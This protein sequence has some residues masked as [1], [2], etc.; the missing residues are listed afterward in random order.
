M[1]VLVSVFVLLSTGIV[2][3]PLVVADLKSD[4]EA[5]ARAKSHAEEYQKMADSERKQAEEASRKV[6]KEFWEETARKAKELAEIHQ[7]EADKFKKE[8]EELTRKEAG[9]PRDKTTLPESPQEKPGTESKGEEPP[10]EE[11]SKK[12]PSQNPAEKGPE[13]TPK[14]RNTPDPWNG[15]EDP[16]PANGIP[17]GE[18]LGK[19]KDEKTEKDIN[20][21]PMYH[22]ENPEFVLLRGKHLWSGVYENGKFTFKYTPKYDEMNSEA[23]EWARRKVAQEGKLIWIME[24]EPPKKCSEETML[25]GFW[26]PGEI[27]WKSTGADETDTSSENEARATGEKGKP[28]PVKLYKVELSKYEEL[29]FQGTPQIHLR[30]EGQPPPS[31][32][33]EEHIAFLTKT[34]PFYIEVVVNEADTGGKD[35]IEIKLK[36]VKAGLTASLKLK[37]QYTVHGLVHYSHDDPI[38]LSDPHVLS[39]KKIQ[40]IWSDFFRLWTRTVNGDDL[41]ISY[42]DNVHSLKMF[43]SYERQRIGQL[44]DAF[45]VA[46]K[47]FETL[48][49]SKSSREQQ[50]YAHLKL[51]YIQN[52]RKLLE[53]KSTSAPE[54]LPDEVLAEILGYYASKLEADVGGNAEGT[55]PVNWVWEPYGIRVS[56]EEEKQEIDRILRVSHEK[57]ADLALSA[58]AQMSVALYQATVANAPGARFIVVV[59]GIDAAGNPV[60][61]TE[62]FL[63]G[64]QMGTQALGFVASSAKTLK[65]L[66]TQGTLNRSG[67]VF[68]KTKD[69]KTVAVPKPQGAISMRPGALGPGG[70]HLGPGVIG[71]SSIHRWPGEDVRLDAPVRVPSFNSLGTPLQRYAD[72]CGPSVLAG[73]Y[74]DAG[75]RVVGV[76][77]K[78][79]LGVVKD[80]FPRLAEEKDV[81]RLSMQQGSYD[82]TKKVNGVTDHGGMYVHQMA[83]MT[84]IAGTHPPQIMLGVPPLQKLEAALHHDYKMAVVI[85]SGPVKNRDVTHWVRL[86]GVRCGRDGRKWVIFGDPHNGASWAAPWSV[87]QRRMV[88]DSTVAVKFKD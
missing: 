12:D 68:A 64:L 3:S 40:V 18:L 71:S 23:P 84:S 44:E 41:E 1:A 10:Q 59:W 15:T 65:S 52:A 86:E 87:F 33:L 7:K 22:G 43:E 48:I 6:P 21:E 19:W 38:L 57:M 83:H 66:H 30:L 35:T 32:D 20:L 58:L 8:A 49:S 88:P 29:A 39:D 62:R 4:Q 61:K 54:Q 9:A 45:N 79:R 75:R 24:L 34:Q 85:Y 36:A 28:I 63:A 16:I 2:A 60:D 13:E 82:I 76:R 50:A 46:D 81:M 25:E 67:K 55:R 73:I 17:V 14:E 56:T 42:G 5:L 11:P 31:E 74:R 53:F 72:T 27:E 26:Y 69:G 80:L 51:R 37:K 77:G 78:Q 70:D 47:V